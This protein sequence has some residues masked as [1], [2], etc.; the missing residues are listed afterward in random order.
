MG[1]KVIEKKV[2]IELTKHRYNNYKH[3]N[4]IKKKPNNRLF[5]LP[6]I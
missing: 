2:F 3:C 6:K 5:L 4:T 1:R